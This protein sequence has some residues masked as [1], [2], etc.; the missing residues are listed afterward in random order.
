MNSNLVFFHPSLITPI[1]NYPHPL[2]DFKQLLSTVSFE[3]IKHSLSLRVSNCIN[4]FVFINFY[5]FCV[6]KFLHLLC[7]RGCSG[8]GVVG[9]TNRGGGGAMCDR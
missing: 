6:Y 8:V 7:L 4:S 2:L 3:P 5:T 9:Y 1:V